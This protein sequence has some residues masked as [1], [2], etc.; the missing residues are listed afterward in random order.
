MF[1][2]YHG[3][4]YHCVTEDLII[5]GNESYRFLTS[6]VQWDTVTIKRIDNTDKNLD[7]NPKVLTSC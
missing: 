5:I 6:S 3:S 4:Q 2:K 7:V 1:K